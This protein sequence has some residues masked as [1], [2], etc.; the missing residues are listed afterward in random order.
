MGKTLTNIKEVYIIPER[1]LL[2]AKPVST[3]DSG[4]T[5]APAPHPDTVL[6][7]RGRFEA[8]DLPY[9]SLQESACQY[10]GSRTYL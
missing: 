1:H 4:Y 6:E 5:V 8:D 7:G 10:P 9:S 3:L 2:R